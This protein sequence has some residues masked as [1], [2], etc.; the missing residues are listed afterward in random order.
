[1][2]FW[3]ISGTGVLVAEIDPSPSVSFF[4]LVKYVMFSW[5]VENAPLWFAWMK[6]VGE[7]GNGSGRT[8]RLGA[9]M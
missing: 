3:V 9:L 7:E 2:R 6:H 5:L 1:M 4:L 8:A